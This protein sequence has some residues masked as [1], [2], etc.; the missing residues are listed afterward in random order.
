[1]FSCGM[2]K[3][4][5]SKNSAFLTEIIHFNDPVKSELK[6]NIYISK[7]FFQLKFNQNLRSVAEQ[8]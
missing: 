2:S 3:Q 7:I 1:M 5:I 4:L 8:L 6:L